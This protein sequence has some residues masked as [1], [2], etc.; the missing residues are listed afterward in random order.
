MQFYNGHNI[1]KIN[2]NTMLYAFINI[3][4]NKYKIKK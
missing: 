3:L 2:I 4:H 1:N